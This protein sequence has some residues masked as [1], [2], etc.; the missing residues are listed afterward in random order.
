MNPQSSTKRCGTLRL[1]QAAVPSG[2][3]PAVPPRPSCKAPKRTPNLPGRHCTRISKPAPSRR[4]SRPTQLGG[5]LQRAL[6]VL[7]AAL[8]RA[9][10]LKPTRESPR[11]PIFLDDIHLALATSQRIPQTI[12]AILQPLDSV[13]HPQS[14]QK[15]GHVASNVSWRVDRPMK[16]LR[17]HPADHRLE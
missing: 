4:S 7:R 16:Q 5:S 1:R 10:R 9:P 12:P 11:Q 3:T 2:A 6:P 13:V 8:L 17:P 15:L 14:P